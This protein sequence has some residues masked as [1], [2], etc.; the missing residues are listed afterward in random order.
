MNRVLRRYAALAVVPMALSLAACTD[1]Q[2]P[3]VPEVPGATE[4]PEDA[5][6][7]AEPTE[8][9][10]DPTDALDV[11]FE[12]GEMLTAGRVVQILQ[13][14]LDGESQRVYNDDYLADSGRTGRLTCRYGV[15]TGGSSP[16]PSPSPSADGPAVEVAVSSYVDEETAAGRIDTTLGSTSRDV[17]PQTIGG[18]EGYLLTDDDEVTY[19]VARG[20]RT[21][22]ITLRRGLV[23]DA[24]E[25][26]VILEL[27][28]EILGDE[29]PEES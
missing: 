29:A 8:P 3:E 4:T 6:D 25:V 18:T 23:P 16:S 1:Q 17:E 9:A 27:A 11:P 2:E 24:A 12:C 28:A 21:Y 26:V 19:I 7:T 20:V 10:G 5:V 15:P 14:P 22:V 13:T